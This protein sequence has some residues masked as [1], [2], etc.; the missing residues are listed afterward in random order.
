[1]SMVSA[2]FR[3]SGQLLFRMRSTKFHRSE[4]AVGP[5]L[6]AVVECGQ[7]LVFEV[8]AW[9][10]SRHRGQGLRRKCVAA[11]TDHVG[12][13]TGDDQGALGVEVLRHARGGVQCDSEPHLAGVGGVDTVRHQEIACRVG[14]VDFEAKLRR[15]VALGE[16]Q[17]VEHRRD[18]EQFEVRFKAHTAAVQRAEQEHPARMVEEQVVFGVADEVGRL[19]HQRCVGNRDAG[20][21]RN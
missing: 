20:N 10:R 21:R 5:V 18:I 2:P 19:A 17:V 16:A 8:G 6:H 7:D 13:D 14:A 15:A 4:G 9:V 11:D 12:L 3:Y 1:M